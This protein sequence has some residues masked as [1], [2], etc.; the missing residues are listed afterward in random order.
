MSQIPTRFNCSYFDQG[1]LL[2]VE[3]YV[4]H[5]GNVVKRYT[6]SLNETY[7]VYPST[8]GYKRPNPSNFNLSRIVKSVIFS[9]CSNIKAYISAKEAYFLNILT[10]IAETTHLITGIGNSLAYYVSFGKVVAFDIPASNEIIP[11]PRLLAFD[12]PQ[13]VDVKPSIVKAVRALPQILKEEPQI[14]VKSVNNQASTIANISDFIMIRGEPHQISVKIKA[15][16]KCEELNHLNSKIGVVKAKV[17]ENAPS[18]FISV[19]QLKALEV[20]CFS[21]SHFNAQ[22]ICQSIQK[23]LANGGNLSMFEVEKG[24]KAP[25]SILIKIASKS[26]MSL[27]SSLQQCF[28]L[29]DK[30]ANPNKQFYRN[31]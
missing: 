2:K 13:K 16:A 29:G 24:L 18:E 9:E 11:E 4:L 26:G 28:K 17:F 15:I 5:N 19:I 22:R 6:N 30:K 8:R 14:E 7:G 27:R 21:Y 12:L 3:G 31:H 25:R 1:L 10:E 23:Y 20:R